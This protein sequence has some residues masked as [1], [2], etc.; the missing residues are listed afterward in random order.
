MNS[1]NTA[2]A[3][4]VDRLTELTAQ[5][6]EGVAAIQDSESGSCFTMLTCFSYP[7]EGDPRMAARRSDRHFMHAEAGGA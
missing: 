4:P 5:L 3:D 2:P 7:S 6:A 1:N